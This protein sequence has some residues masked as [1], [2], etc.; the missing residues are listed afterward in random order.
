MKEKVENFVNSLVVGVNSPICFSTPRFFPLSFLSFNL[1]KDDFFQATLFCH[2]CS[3]INISE[4]ILK[5]AVS[6]R[7]ICGFDLKLSLPGTICEKKFFLGSTHLKPFGYFSSPSLEYFF[8]GI[9]AHFV[10]LV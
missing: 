3:V 9:Y 1:K 5:R 6:I 10:N 4:I 7:R 2:S 8:P